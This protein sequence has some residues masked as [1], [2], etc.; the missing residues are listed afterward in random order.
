MALKVLKTR[1]FDSKSYYVLSAILINGKLYE[2]N[3]ILI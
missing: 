2:F 3:F 1:K